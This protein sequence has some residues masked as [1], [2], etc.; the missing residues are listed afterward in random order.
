MKDYKANI[1]YLK[2]TDRGECCVVE[3]ILDPPM[4]DDETLD[5][6]EQPSLIMAYSII[7]ALQSRETTTQESSAPYKGMRGMK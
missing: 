3:V 7:T 4:A 2:L 1:V 5:N 6:N